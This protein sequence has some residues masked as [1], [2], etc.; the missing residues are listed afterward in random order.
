MYL[1]DL[2]THS[3]LSMDGNVPLSEMARS[4]VNAGLS[5][6]AVTDHHD[7]LTEDGQRNLTY[8]WA[9][10]L[11]Q[12]A[13][14]VPQFEGKLDLRLGLELGSVR[15]PM[16]ALACEDDKIVA[17]AQAMIEAAIAKL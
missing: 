16:P 4:A 9:P 11:A 12:F 7:M 10:A 1:T 17:Q 6:L 14:T 2:H 8:D 5:M 3:I 15:E 13:G